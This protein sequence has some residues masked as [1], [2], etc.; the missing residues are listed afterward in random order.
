MRVENTNG[1][2]FSQTVN[3]QPISVLKVP[4][5]LHAILLKKNNTTLPLFLT[6][7]FSKLESLKF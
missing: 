1:N 4:D 7:I 3:V 6:S 2:T 5:D